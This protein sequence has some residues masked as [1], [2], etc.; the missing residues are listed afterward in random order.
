VLAALDVV[1]EEGEG[2]EADVGDVEVQV[3]KHGWTPTKTIHD[4]ANV[5]SSLGP[6]VFHLYILV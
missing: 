5:T 6:H 4:I 2:E 3:T 1:P